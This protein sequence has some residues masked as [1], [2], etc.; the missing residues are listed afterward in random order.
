MPTIAPVVIGPVTFLYIDIDASDPTSAM[1]TIIRNGTD[2]FKLAQDG[3][4]Q[5]LG[6]LVQSNVDGMTD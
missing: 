1:L 4:I 2:S 6:S 5:T 3:T